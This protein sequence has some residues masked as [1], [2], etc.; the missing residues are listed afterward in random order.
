MSSGLPYLSLR[1]LLNLL[2]L[3]LEVINI[4]FH[5]Q[6]GQIY[7]NMDFYRTSLS[8]Q[9]N[10][11]SEFEMFK[12]EFQKLIYKQIE[13]CWNHEESANY[14]NIWE[15]FPNSNMVDVYSELCKVEDEGLKTL[16][17]QQSTL[18]SLLPSSFSVVDKKSGKY[19]V[20][21]GLGQLP[22]SLLNNKMKEIAFSERTDDMS[23]K[24]DPV[25]RRVSLR[26]K[27]DE[28]D[29][30]IKALE[31]HIIG[32]KERRG[33]GSN[34]N[35]NSLDIIET[36]EDNDLDEPPS[37]YPSRYPCL[38]NNISI[39]IPANSA[40]QPK[41]LE[42]VNRFLKSYCERKITKMMSKK[43]DGKT[44]PTKSIHSRRNS[45]KSPTSSESI[46]RR[47][48]LVETPEPIIDKS[49]VIDERRK[50]KS[51]FLGGT[52]VAEGIR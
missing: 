37:P 24:D 41:D 2:T 51:D 1:E 21:K 18:K 27:I 32:V 48:T 45:S 30:K 49:I 19:D 12:K 52:S 50:T 16:L 11:D 35:E 28:N 39:M 10:G 38:M 36:N 6:N 34:I 25:I 42:E 7:L 15:F 4:V 31:K 44:S 33:T 46:V 47:V 23:V 26:T 29:E 5:K 3:T 9:N 22:D 40:E 43:F 13:D 17:K 14:K 8:L 20:L